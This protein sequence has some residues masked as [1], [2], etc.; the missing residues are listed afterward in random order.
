M[1]VSMVFCNVRKELSE[2]SKRE[3]RTGSEEALKVQ[4][5]FSKNVVHQLG[6]SYVLSLSIVVEG[7]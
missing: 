7:K 1:K 6:D 2:F 3:T 4:L 5:R